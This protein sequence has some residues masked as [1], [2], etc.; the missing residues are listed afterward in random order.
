MLHPEGTVTC[1]AWS[2]DDQQVSFI[3]V[4]ILFF[5]YN[6]SCIMFVLLSYEQ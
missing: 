3:D 6:M 4:C 5:V 1:G 2:P